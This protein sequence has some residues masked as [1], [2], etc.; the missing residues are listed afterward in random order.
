MI[1][2]IYKLMEEEE[3]KDIF[4]FVNLIEIQKLLINYPQLYILFEFTCLHINSLLKTKKELNIVYR[5]IY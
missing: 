1:K 2:S 3:S 5:S 4:K